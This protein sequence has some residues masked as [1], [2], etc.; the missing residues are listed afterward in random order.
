MK[1]WRKFAR[2]REDKVEFMVAVPQQS[3]N[4]ATTVPSGAPKV[5]QRCPKGPPSGP[6]KVPQGSSNRP[7]EGASKGLPTQA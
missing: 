3:P 6:P 5:H 7:R 2:G 1:G 4:G